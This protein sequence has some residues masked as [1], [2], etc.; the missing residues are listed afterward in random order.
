MSARRALQS[1][2]GSLLDGVVWSDLRPRMKI[3]GWLAETTLGLEHTGPRAPGG[4][5]TSL[6]A[7]SVDSESPTP[8]TES[9]YSTPYLALHAALA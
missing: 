6:S 1:F 8:T 5:I 7:S 2:G 4:K 9:R 3:N